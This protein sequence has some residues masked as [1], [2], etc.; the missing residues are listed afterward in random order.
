MH[1]RPTYKQLHIEPFSTDPA[2]VFIAAGHP[3]AERAHPSWEE[4]NEVGFVL[5]ASPSKLGVTAR[6]LD[7]LKRRGLKPN[8][9]LRCDS[10]ETKNA[11]VKSWLGIGLGFSWV[12]NR[13]SNAANSSSFHYP[14]FD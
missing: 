6:F 2:T 5:V 7:C 12:S 3:L 9:A 11:A 13:N 4:M 14:E 1:S 10:E 8:I